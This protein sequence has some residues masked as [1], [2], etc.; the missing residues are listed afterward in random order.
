MNSHILKRF[1][2]QFYLAKNA[3]EKM[4]QSNISF[5]INYEKGK[6]LSTSLCL[7]PEE[8]IARFATVLRPLADPTSPVYFKSIA[9]ILF[10]R[11]FI[12]ISE[13]EKENLIKDVQVIQSGPLHIKMNDEPLS[14][15][16]MYLLYAKGEYFSNEDAAA[17]KLKRFITNPVFHQLL[18]FQFYSY[19]LDVYKI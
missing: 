16:D 8:E 17:N 18:L 3:A 9:S 7:P 1:K 4:S 5:K 11:D 14:A 19:S 13:H 10:E 2:E 6:G 12:K 15:L